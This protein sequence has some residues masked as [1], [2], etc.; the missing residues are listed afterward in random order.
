MTDTRTV[1]KELTTQVH[2]NFVKTYNMAN[3]EG[4]GY[5]AGYLES[6]LV[7]AIDTMPPKARKEYMKFVEDLKAYSK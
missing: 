3:H 7:R 1:I 2:A 6:M 4:Y 5:V